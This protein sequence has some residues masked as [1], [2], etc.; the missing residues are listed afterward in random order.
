MAVIRIPP[1]GRFSRTALTVRLRRVG[2]EQETTAA[3]V[4]LAK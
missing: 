2:D 3:A 4:R 1:A